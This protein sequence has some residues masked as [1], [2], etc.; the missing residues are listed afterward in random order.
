MHFSNA[1]LSPIERQ[2]VINN[3]EILLKEIASG[4]L[5]CEKFEIDSTFNHLS[6]LIRDINRYVCDLNFTFKVSI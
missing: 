1:L 5:E 3:Q 2:N 6:I 4:V